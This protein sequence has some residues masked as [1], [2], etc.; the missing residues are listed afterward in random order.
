[1]KIWFKHILTTGMILAGIALSV[2]SYF[3]MNSAYENYEYDM[4]TS[5]IISLSLRNLADGKIPYLVSAAMGKNVSDDSELAMAEEETGTAQDTQEATE[6]TQTGEN[7]D[8]QD[9]EAVQNPEDS[10]NEAGLTEE[11]ANPE[12]E[13]QADPAANGEAG[14]NAENPAAENPS[15]NP[16]QTENSETTPQEAVAAEESQEI[17][18]VYTMT[19]VE[20]DYFDDA[21]F[22]GDSRTVG[23][24]EYC[25]ELMER[26]EFYA[27]VS[28][29][30]YGTDDIKFVEVPVIPEG[31]EPEVAESAKEQAS[32]ESPEASDTGENT[33][34][35]A[36][37][38]NAQAEPTP[39]PDPYAD[40]P[41]EKVTIEEALTRKQFGKI[42]MMLGINELG[43]GTPETFRDKYGEVIGRIRE[44]QPDAIIYIQGIM[45]VT[46]KKSNS[47][48]V[49][50]NETINQR[51]DA[52][53]ELADWEH[54]FYI[55]MNEATDDENGALS[56][57]L[58]FDDVHLKAK[59]YSLWYDYLKNH[60][61][62]KVPKDEVDT[63]IKAES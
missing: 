63:G 29:T 32:E 45:H 7:R 21:L 30:I 33:Q 1:M 43:S 37:E 15:E 51:N 54:I 2:D 6:T 57:D 60:A 27:K 17:K 44:L 49:F 34:E 8:V 42:Y 36:T 25:P 56:Q 24:S 26:S 52:L 48:K 61:F 16:E 31:F 13:N 18:Y 12:G 23:L 41:K 38:E 39:T 5:P 55:D 10:Q 50:K 3:G 62:I 14:E 28:M 11:I 19:S 46:S 59:S 9:T 40:L 4:M 47:D 58:S 35:T 22:I 53:R 20:D